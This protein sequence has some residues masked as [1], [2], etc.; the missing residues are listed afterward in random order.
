MSIN[1]DNKN[2]RTLL[3]FLLAFCAIALYATSN[4]NLTFVVSG[5]PV[6]IELSEQPIVTYRDNTLHVETK[7]QAFDITVS[8]IDFAII[9][10]ETT[11]SISQ[12]AGILIRNGIASFSQLPPGS[13]VSVFT[14]GGIKVKDV[15]VDSKGNTAV[16]FGSCPKGTYILKSAL[17]TIKYIKK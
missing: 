17:H 14:L 2:Q 11:T 4:E 3:M 13:Q 1:L 15:T 6:S 16:N 8:D 12:P 7:T 5:R 10:D 9:K